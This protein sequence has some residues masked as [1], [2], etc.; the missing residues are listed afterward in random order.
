M[1][2]HLIDDA[3]FTT[4]QNLL[5]ERGSDKAACRSNSYDYLLTRLL[6]CRLC[7]KRYVGAS[8]HGRYARYEYYVCHSRQKYG[9]TGC[10]A[11]RLPARELEEAVIDAIGSVFSDL[12]F[13][14]RAFTTAAERTQEVS[15]QSQEELN[16]VEAELKKTESA[17]DR[18]LAAFED[19]SMSSAQ[20]G[21][22]LEQLSGRLRQLQS[23]RDEI[24][25]LDRQQ[26]N[27]PDPERI[28]SLR[29]DL[30]LAL[31]QG[32]APTVK[33]VLRE[34]VDS[35]DVHD[36]RL[37][38]PRFRIPGAVRTHSSLAVPTGFEPVSPP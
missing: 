24:A 5:A 30:S 27:E 31:S 4:A 16:Q 28:A 37:V 11:D 1:H 23:R 3:T 35:I 26:A 2:R 12:D 9:T 13:V 36:H 21:P 33:T 10:T 38:R 14:E 34:L 17:I 20:C 15:G 6:V 18:Y 22:R 29:F 19:G 8:A 25:D 7:G 32:E